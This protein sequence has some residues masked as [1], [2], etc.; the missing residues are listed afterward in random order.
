MS[1]LHRRANPYEKEMERGR[2]GGERERMR[3][4]GARDKKKGWGDRKEAG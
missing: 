1:D 2:E 3:R 4:G